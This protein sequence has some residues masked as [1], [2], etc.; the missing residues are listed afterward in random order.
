MTDAWRTGW[1]ADGAMDVT[2]TES[3][4]DGGTSGEGSVADAV[5]S[6][7]NG[8]AIDVTQ[9]VW[10]LLHFRAARTSKLNFMQQRRP[11]QLSHCP[12]APYTMRQS[13]CMR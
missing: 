7:A 2:R 5:H 4:G 9:N 1:R 10:P 13:A 12:V 6:R 11:A 3:D 8:D